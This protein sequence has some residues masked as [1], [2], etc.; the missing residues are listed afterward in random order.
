MVF[1]GQHQVQTGQE[2]IPRAALSM[3]V[4]GLSLHLSY[5]LPM[6]CP[7]SEGAT[8]WD[9]DPSA[10]GLLCL[11]TAALGAALGHCAGLALPKTGCPARSGDRQGLG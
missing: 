11:L 2:S 8:S 9:N 1:L 6:E 4:D 5:P 10:E 3:G 7:C